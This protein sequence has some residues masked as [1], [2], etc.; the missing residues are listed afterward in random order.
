MYLSMKNEL[1]PAERDALIAETIENYRE[2]LNPGFIGTKKSADAKEVEWRAEGALMYDVYGKAFIDCLA[3]YGV[4]VLG[5][6]PKPVIDA[7]LHVY[8]RMGLYSQE[9]LNPLQGDLAKRLAGIT[10]GDLKFTYFH[11]GGGESNDAAIKMARAYHRV[12]HKDD[13]TIHVTFRNA[14]HGKTFGALAAT[15]RPILKHRFHPMVPGIGEP[16]TVAE[17]G[18]L[19]SLAHILEHVGWKTASVIVEAVQGEGGIVIP[20]AEFLPGVR[21]LCDKYGI[22]MH[23]DEVQSGFCRSGKMFCAEHTGVA[24]DIMTMAKAMSG[25]VFPIS[26]TIVTPEV[27]KGVIENPWYL[28]N[29]FAGSAP[30]CAAALAA[31][32]MMER[33]KVA[34]QSRDKGEYFK[35]GLAEIAAEFPGVVR[36]VRGKGLWIGVEFECEDFGGKV[37]K[38]LFERDVLSAH[39]INNPRVMRLQPPAIIERELLDEVLDR[40]RDTMKAVKAGL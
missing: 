6:R 29:T 30:G 26:A 17:Y 12:V 19:D 18:D 3:G 16:G 36:E 9:L 11:L 25:G 10:P 37:S 32:D 21:K 33:E 22:L 13:R 34:D 1:T 39:T 5:H 14:F 35:A 31:I 4:F 2:Y 20:P 7:V 40:F 27:I 24:P 8:E 28:S 38:G 15:N 23:V